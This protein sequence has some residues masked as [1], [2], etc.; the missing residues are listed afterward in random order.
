MSNILSEL[1]AD[2]AVNIPLK[3]LFSYRVPESLVDAAQV[4]MRVKIPFG[5]R[6]TVGFL[7]GLRQGEAEGLKD[8][9]ELLD[10]EPMLTPELIKLL[11]WAA[12]YY[13]HPV[14]QVVRT[15]LPAGLGGD[16]ATT[17]ILREAF[18]LS[19]IHI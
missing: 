8:L 11:R 5:R 12:D 10:N 18:Y 7:L 3:Q 2:I 16:K 15:A 19:L 17:K 13:C 4:G 1:I 14:G 6:T 9:Q